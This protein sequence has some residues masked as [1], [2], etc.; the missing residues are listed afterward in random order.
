MVKVQVIPRS[1]K[2][3]INIYIREFEVYYV[4]Q[5]NGIKRS[6]NL[7]DEATKSCFNMWVKHNSKENYQVQ[8][9]S[10]DF[11]ILKSLRYI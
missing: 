9:S 11:Y 3:I 10:Y 2:K 6:F 4:N 5:Y 8:L 7:F 1:K